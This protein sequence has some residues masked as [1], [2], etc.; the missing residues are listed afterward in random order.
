[1]IRSLFILMVWVA[2]MWSATADICEPIP[3][4]KSL[5]G[6]AKIAVTQFEAQKQ[7]HNHH[8]MI[9]KM[10]TKFLNQHFSDVTSVDIDYDGQALSGKIGKYLVTAY[11]QRS[12]DGVEQRDCHTIDYWVEDVDECELKL[13]NC[14]KTA[15]CTNT[16]GSYECTCPDGFNGVATY[17][18]PECG[19]NKDTS[20]CCL[21]EK[22]KGAFVCSDDP[23]D[24]HKCHSLANCVPDSATHTYECVCKEGYV[25]DGFTC[26]KFTAPN[27]CQDGHTCV[28]PCQCVNDFSQN[29]YR[30]GVLSSPSLCHIA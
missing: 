1:M 27:Y 4:E 26:E 19:G 7:S 24:N 6:F 11:I 3:D 25:G 9:I 2:N 22:C 29:G 23:C 17:N 20:Q 13:H 30:C 15:L 21:D 8:N 5:T 16:I 18:S 28:T 10:T 14:H 12:V